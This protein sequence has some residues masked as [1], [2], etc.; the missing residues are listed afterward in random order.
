M[1]SMISVVCVVLALSVWGRDLQLPVPRQT[2]GMPLLDALAARQT[3]RNFSEQALSDQLLSDLLW[4]AFGI[5]RDDGKRTAPSARNSQEIDLYVA[6]PTGL[7]LYDAK[8]NRLI[9]ILSD[10]IREK[11]GVQPF[12]QKAPVNLIYVSETDRL[13]G[14]KEFYSAADT[15]FISQ[16]VYLFCASEGLNTVVLGWVEKEAL[17]KVMDLKPSQHII[18]T[19][20]VGFPAE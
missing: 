15:G 10:D 12:T 19:Q 6:L 11:T 20:P 16:N 9:Q 14:D 8:A 13:R 17:H 2:G 1:K 3:N 7:Y 4:A 18:L 5:N